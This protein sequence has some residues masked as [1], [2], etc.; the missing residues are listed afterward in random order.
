MGFEIGERLQA[1][2][3]EKRL[4]DLGELAGGPLS[5][6]RLDVISAAKILFQP[7]VKTDKQITA[8]HFLYFELSLAGAPVAPG[9]GND[10][11]TITPHDRFERDFDG[12]I[13][14]R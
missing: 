6:R 7:N 9:D 8:A 11:P 1:E 3:A 2:V 5:G 13:E 4:A 12:Q 10:S 14:M